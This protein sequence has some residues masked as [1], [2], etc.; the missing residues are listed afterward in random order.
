MTL[1]CDNNFVSI[2]SW[3]DAVYCNTAEMV[4]ENVMIM[5]HRKHI[6]EWVGVKGIT[7]DNEES[8]FY[9]SILQSIT[10]D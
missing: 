2:M 1:N 4:Y 8:L 5:E 7:A 3:R 10:I 6:T 9:Q